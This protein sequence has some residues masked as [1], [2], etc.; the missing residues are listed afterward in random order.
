M[1]R[2]AMFH[3]AGRAAASLSKCP[4]EALVTRAGWG[5]GEGGVE[6]GGSVRG[7]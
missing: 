5:V 7:C 6:E 4:P 1:A 2:C 3:E